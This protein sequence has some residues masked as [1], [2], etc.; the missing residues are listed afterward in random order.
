MGCYIGSD[1]GTTGTKTV[2]IDEK[3]KLLGK[4][5]V[6]HPLSTPKPG[7]AEQAP[8]DRWKSAVESIRSALKQG[9]EALEPGEPRRDN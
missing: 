1:I 9:R 3:G 6:E 2:V 7:W 8:A 4:S 5:T